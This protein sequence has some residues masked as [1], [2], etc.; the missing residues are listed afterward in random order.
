MALRKRALSIYF[1]TL[2]SVHGVEKEREIQIEKETEID[3]FVMIFDKS[4]KV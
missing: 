1:F 2:D 3:L 4:I